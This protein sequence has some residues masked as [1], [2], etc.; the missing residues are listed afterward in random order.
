M[1]VSF[2]ENIIVGKNIMKNM[3]SGVVLATAV[4][5]FGASSANAVEAE[6]SAQELRTAMV[7]N[8]LSGKSASGIAVI[9]TAEKNGVLKI[10]FGKKT[11]TGTWKIRDDGKWC[12]TLSG[13]VK[14]QSVK[15]DGKTLSFYDPN[16]DLSAKLSM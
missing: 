12:R 4:F 7:G 14:C 1:R 16:G 8:A 5:V 2:L 15:R 3:I 10:S 13:Q 11:I 6:I 9:I